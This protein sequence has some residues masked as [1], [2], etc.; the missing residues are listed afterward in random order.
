MEVFQYTV[1]FCGVLEFAEELVRLADTALDADGGL[2][3]RR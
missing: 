3:L 2:F 1:F